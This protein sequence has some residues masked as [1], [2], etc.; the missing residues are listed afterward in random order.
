[1][2][3]KYQLIGLKSEQFQR[4]VRENSCHGKLFISTFTFGAMPVFSSIMHACILY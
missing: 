1:M 2:S 3:G 4:S